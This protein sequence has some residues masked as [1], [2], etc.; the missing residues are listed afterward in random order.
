[1]QKSAF[2]RS[3]IFLDANKARKRPLRPRPIARLLGALV[4][5]KEQR[6]KGA[7]IL[8][9][10]GRLV[11]ERRGN[12][13]IPLFLRDAL[14]LQPDL[15]AAYFN[16]GLAYLKAGDEAKGRADLS[17]AGELGIMAAY[18]ILKRLGD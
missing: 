8:A 7:R 17:K 2:F 9:D 10:D 11:K 16:R 5:Q 4:L 18:N 14:R 3:E 6:R 15:A 12:G 1:M 13:G